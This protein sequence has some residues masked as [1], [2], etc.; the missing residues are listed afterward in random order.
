MALGL[1]HMIWSLPK[2]EINHHRVHSCYVATWSRTVSGFQYPIPKCPDVSHYV[3]QYNILQGK[4][5]KIKKNKQRFWDVIICYPEKS[6]NTFSVAPC[7]SLQPVWPGKG[8]LLWYRK[9]HQKAS[10][11]HCVIGLYVSIFFWL[12]IYLKVTY[13]SDRKPTATSWLW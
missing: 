10:I 8:L 12:S 3:W 6:T 2:P 13:L 9:S 11:D 4:N 5:R 7:T 1:P